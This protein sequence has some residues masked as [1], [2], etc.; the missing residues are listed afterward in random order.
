MAATKWVGGIDGDD[1]EV[2]GKT[3]VLEAVVEQRHLRSRR[4]GG[5]DSGNAV[6]VGHM[7]HVWQQDGQFG[8]LVAP[9]PTGRPIAT[10]HDGRPHAVG[11]HRTGQPGHQWRLPCATEREVADRN[12]RYRPLGD[13]QQAVIVGRIAAADHQAVGNGK[14]T[15]GEPCQR[16]PRTA[17]R[18]VHQTLESLGVGEQGHFSGVLCRQGCR[19]KPQRSLP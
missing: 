17:G 12:D 18:A 2:A 5:A 10:A 8:S 11:G 9:F 13:W 16:R 19:L 14:S 7:G 1:V 3:T 6:T 15:Q 4:C